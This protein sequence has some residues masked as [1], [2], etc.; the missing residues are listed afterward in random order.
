[1][2][3]VPLVNQDAAAAGAK[4]ILLL[5]AAP[6]PF[7]SAPV[8][9][10]VATVHSAVQRVRPRK[11]GEEL[12]QR[13][14]ITKG[15]VEL[16]LGRAPRL[17]AATGSLG[18]AQ[19]AEALAS[20][21]CRGAAA[22]GS[23]PYVVLHARLRAALPVPMAPGG[24]LPGLNAEPQVVGEQDGEEEQGGQRQAPFLCPLRVGE[25]LVGVPRAEAH[26]RAGSSRGAAAHISGARSPGRLHGDGGSAAGLD[27]PTGM[28]TGRRG[29]RLPPQRRVTT[30][31]G[32]AAAALLVRMV[33]MV[34]VLLRAGLGRAGSRPLPPSPFP[35]PGH[36]QSTGPHFGA[37]TASPPLPTRRLMPRSTA[38]TPHP[39]ALESHP[40]KP[41]DCA[42]ASPRR[43]PGAGLAATRQV[44]GA[45]G[46]LPERRG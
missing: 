15:K 13:I 35:S 10:V 31:V 9:V 16:R 30:G 41:A 38:P 46:E 3:I 36:G 23:P 45:A 39:G 7:P 4:P 18:V 6:V 26:A 40:G 27:G 24:D 20:G 1:M 37:N 28:D 32:V 11:P 21:R 12:A 44:A 14:G 29:A 5:P 43:A 17:Q 2:P 25:G 33:A 22:G 42:P 8:A 19:Q 34:L